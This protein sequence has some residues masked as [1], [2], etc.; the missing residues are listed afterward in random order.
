MLIHIVVRVEA[1]FTGRRLSSNQILEFLE[2][3]L[4]VAADSVDGTL[5]NEALALLH[6]APIERTLSEDLGLGLIQ[7]EVRL[8]FGPLFDEPVERG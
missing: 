1:C 5:I 8:L 6:G 2:S 7:R 3:I 4:G